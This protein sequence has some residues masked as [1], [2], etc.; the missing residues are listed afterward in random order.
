MPMCVKGI[1]HICLTSSLPASP[2]TSTHP[3]LH[4]PSQ[5]LLWRLRIWWLAPI[6]LI[7]ALTLC[8]IPPSA[9]PAPASPFLPLSGTELTKSARIIQKHF[10]AQGLPSDGLLF[11]G[12]AL[13]E[14]AKAAVLNFLDQG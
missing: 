4:E 11:P 1:V 9:A 7:L 3:H 5:K 12:V 14:P 6:W 2:E 13:A 10:A 8:Q